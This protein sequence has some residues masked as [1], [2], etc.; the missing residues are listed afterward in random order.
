MT[1][2]SRPRWRDLLL[3]REGIAMSEFALVTP[4]FLILLMGGAELAN[5][6]TVRMRIS[7]LTSQVADNAARIGSG[8]QLQA[9]QIDEAQIN[10]LL[11][12]ANLQAEGLDLAKK[13]RVIVSSLENDPANAGKYHIQWQRCYGDPTYKPVW[14]KQGD[15]NLAGMGPENR[16][17]VMPDNATMVVELNYK[18]EPL[19]AN[20]FSTATF[21]D[22][23]E[24]FAM[25]VRDRRALSKPPNAVAGVKPSTCV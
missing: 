17:K 6:M 1:V 2:R 18:Y 14:G 12:G 9:K 13:G 22:F 19:I 11:T 10:D 16:I 5:Y 4:V 7:Q 23:T 25:P 21:G 8:T 15:A 20:K 24:L 3:A